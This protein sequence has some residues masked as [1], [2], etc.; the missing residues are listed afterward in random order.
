MKPLQDYQKTRSLVGW[1]LRNRR[2]QSTRPHLASRE[3][4]QVGC[5]P[6]IATGF[7]NLDYRWVPGVDVVWDLMNPLPFP[8]NRFSGIFTEHCLEHFDEASLRKTLGELFRILRPSGRLRVVVP[9]LE[10]HARLYLETASPSDATPAN[11]IN[12]V[13]Y[14]GHDWMQRSR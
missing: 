2:F 6:Q 14:S 10:A 7:L 12:R 8:S 5:G 3:Y 4:L 11:R 13:F 9:C 1:L